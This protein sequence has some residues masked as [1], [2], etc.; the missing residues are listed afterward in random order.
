MIIELI[1]ILSVIA[2]K[3]FAR[4]RRRLRHCYEREFDVNLTSSTYSVDH[5][6]ASATPGFRL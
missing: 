5:K 2:A 3:S 1:L 6:P 4:P